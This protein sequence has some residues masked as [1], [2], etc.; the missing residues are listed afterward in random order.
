MGA[1]YAP[2]ATGGEPRNPDFKID[3]L[4]LPADVSAERFRGRQSLRARVEDRLRAAEAQAGLDDL[5]QLYGKALELLTS[6]RVR[7]AFDI[8]LEPPARRDR[9]GHTKL[10]QRCLLA[11]RLLEAG[12]RFVMV[13]Y[14]YDWGE[15]NN[16]WDNHCAPGQN[17]PHI[18]KMAKVPYH[19]PAVDQA[20]AA[21]LD[22]LH[23]SGRL[24]RTLMVYL[25]E[26]GRTPKINKAGGRDHWG[27][28]GSIF[29]AGGGVRGGQVLGATD[30]VGGYCT[31]RTWS[32]ADAVATVYRAVG[33]DP[34]ATILNRESRPNPILPA[35]EPI[36][37]F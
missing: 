35:G 25:T 21:L 13:D 4:A 31:T 37:V 6:P 33:I 24:R 34:H 12:A 14:G 19:L 22:D 29:F 26:F 8:R 2:F 17:Q 27:Y 32:P 30:K 5:D 11:H 18:S 3:A 36:P 28:S 23:A 7:Q 10:G 20:F 16:L 9:Y 15:Y 1:R